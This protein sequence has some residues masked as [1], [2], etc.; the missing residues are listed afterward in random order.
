MSCR[1]RTCSMNSVNITIIFTKPLDVGK[2]FLN[3][4]RIVCN[5][6]SIHQIMHQT[7]SISISNAFIKDTYLRSLY[8]SPWISLF[9]NLSKFFFYLKVLFPFCGVKKKNVINVF[10][11]FLLESN[12]TN[13]A[14][15]KWSLIEM[16]YFVCWGVVSG[17]I[18][19]WNTP[20]MI[21]MS[22]L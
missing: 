2:G 7:L 22:T 1:Q 20:A 11:L 18:I 3:F 12:I 9:C 21:D 8:I 14:M 4:T 17:V 19:W 5:L 13:Y 6:L 16:T 15:I 10:M